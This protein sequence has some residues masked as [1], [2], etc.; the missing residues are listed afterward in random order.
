LLSTISRVEGFCHIIV[1]TQCFVQKPL[2][3]GRV[4]NSMY[5]HATERILRQEKSTACQ[6]SNRA[7]TKQQK[8][9]PVPITQDLGSNLIYWKRSLFKERPCG[10][11]TETDSTATDGAASWFSVRGPR[12]R[13]LPYCSCAVNSGRFT[14]VDQP[15]IMLRSVS[16]PSAKTRITCGTTKRT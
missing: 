2:L 4:H 16:H 10:F 14:R 5:T 11:S 15:T 1:D 7:S 9:A 13:S 3:R 8:V 12:N 6:R